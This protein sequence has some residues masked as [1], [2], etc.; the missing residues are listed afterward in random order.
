LLE[1]AAGGDRLT[2]AR[3]LFSRATPEVIEQIVRWSEKLEGAQERAEAL[4]VTIGEDG[5]AKARAYQ[6]AVAD[7]DLALLGM[8]NVIAEALRPELEEFIGDIV[9]LAK[10]GTLK[11]WA[12]EGAGLIRDFAR[13]TKT[14]VEVVADLERPIRAA[15]AA[16]VAYRG[17]TI[18]SEIVLALASDFK[19]LAGALGL[20]A[21]AE[22]AA[23]LG[24]ASVVRIIV[25]AVAF[26]I[27][28]E[29]A[30]GR[31]AGAIQGAVHWLQEFLGLGEQ[32]PP[33]PEETLRANA[34]IAG[35]YDRLITAARKAGDEER[36]LDLERQKSATLAA[37]A[38]EA[39]RPR[40]VT[41]EALP[42]EFEGAYAPHAT[43]VP[44]PTAGEPALGKVTPDPV[45]SGDAARKKEF[46]AIE[47][48]ED[49]ELKRA[50]DNAAERYRITQ[51]YS[52]LIIAKFGAESEE[53]QKQA[54]KVT[55][56]AA[57]AGEQRRKLVEA[58][59]AAELKA[60]TD[61]IDA[62]KALLEERQKNG[63]IT[64]AEEFEGLKA[65]LAKK[66]ALQKAYLAEQLAL[67]VGGSEKA[68]ALQAAFAGA[69]TA[70]QRTQVVIDAQVQN[71]EAVEKLLQA[72]EELGPAGQ[73]SSAELA[74]M[75]DPANVAAQQSAS[76]IREA[77]TTVFDDL[78]RGFQQV[79]QGILQ[80]TTTAAQAVRQA[81]TSLAAEGIATA[82][83]FVAEVIKLQL[84]RVASEVAG[85]A[86]ILDAD[87][88]Q[89]AQALAL[90][91]GN[92][93]RELVTFK[94]VQT[95][96][97]AAQVAGDQAQVASTAV[98]GVE[99][100]A[101][102]GASAKKSIVTKAAEAAAGA[103]DAMSSIPYV[104]PV[105][106]AVAAAAVFAAVL[107]FGSYVSAE[108]GM[109]SA[110]GN[111]LAFLH[112]EERVLP[113][114]TAATVRAL[115]RSPAGL[116]LLNDGSPTDIPAAGATTPIAA[117]SMV[118]PAGLAEEVRGGGAAGPRSGPRASSAGPTGRVPAR[119]PREL[120]NQLLGVQ[121]NEGPV[122]AAGG[123]DRVPADNTLAVL[124]RD[125]AVVPAIA[126]EPL[127]TTTAD[128]VAHPGGRGAGDAGGDAG[129]GTLVH[130]K[131]AAGEPG[132]KG[133][134]KA[135]GGEHKVKHEHTGQIDHTASGKA[136]PANMA[137]TGFAGGSSG[138]GGAKTQ[139]VRVVAATPTL[140]TKVQGNVS[141]SIT[142][143]V[144]TMPVGGVTPVE[145]Q[146]G[147]KPVT[148]ANKVPVSFNAVQTMA[149]VTMS[150]DIKPFGVGAGI[151]FGV[152]FGSI[153]AFKGGGDVPEDMLAKLHNRE[154]VLPVDIAE[155]FR[156]AIRR[157]GGITIGQPALSAPRSDV[158][159]GATAAAASTSASSA[160]PSI[161]EEHH[162]HWD[163]KANDAA[164]FQDMLQRHGKGVIE[165]TASDVVSRREKTA[166]R[167]F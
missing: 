36:A 76:M 26:L 46:E 112:P 6:A 111:A 57:A 90:K 86:Q 47:R 153:N 146:G 13:G 70:E 149:S 81:E 66:L 155:P 139:D 11:Q 114:A 29:N 31:V 128:A 53:A 74:R 94:S 93:L 19:A 77:F 154:M 133:G 132:G 41:D 28:Y 39:A 106:G 127:R 162:H 20:V 135:D 1:A 21:V 121:I 10:D 138:G 78:D 9:D 119:V 65:L 34:A 166:G 60:R 89:G 71:P 140:N 3:Q 130:E 18:T 50:G 56:A 14:A 99:K 37:R 22:D 102:E 40:R 104:G 80:G 72:I 85:N 142:K 116:A 49:Q 137:I 61:E 30:W 107:A 151:A 79:I 75:F 42:F 38:A 82:E 5:V 64:Q 24:I 33:S 126:A 35:S 136:T 131:G 122:S 25:T 143:A 73:R 2:A 110:P 83:H 150:T 12:T 55:E 98:A 163:V 105:L 101:V 160:T 113:P 87:K 96:K 124:H 48:L 145:Q 4:G 45:G 44:L 69:G 95:T 8:K 92:W 165:K 115:T 32:K 103:Y 91:V 27:T 117:G 118:L 156:A 67:E 123:L 120:L 43:D 59:V 141:T 7:M 88:L 167:R 109:E 15:A 84:L 152:G 23:T 62:E 147:P 17:A 129:G 157:P 51:Q 54:V 58:N 16:W 97:V 134:G 63:E 68:T 164:S 144:E 161:V 100:N 158:G 159:A 125:E 148:V 52:D 108:Q